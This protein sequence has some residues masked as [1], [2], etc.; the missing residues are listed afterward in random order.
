MMLFIVAKL[1]LMALFFLKKETVVDMM[2][3]GVGY[4]MAYMVRWNVVCR[5]NSCGK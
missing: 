1:F 4:G 3:E 5:V 2:V